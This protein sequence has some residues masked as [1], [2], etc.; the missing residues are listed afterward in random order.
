MFCAKW[1]VKENLALS[2][3]GSTVTDNLILFKLIYGNMESDFF[4]CF[5]LLLLLCY[6]ILYFS[7]LPYLIIC[8]YFCLSY[9]V[10]NSPKCF[11][12][13]LKILSPLATIPLLTK[14]PKSTSLTW[15][16][17]T[18]WSATSTQTLNCFLLFL[19]HP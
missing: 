8:N 17:S 15:T 12:A 5:L 13:N 16:D 4:P 7:S 18:P 9:I 2:N 14:T 1:V 6:S 10:I 3:S 19:F 11:L